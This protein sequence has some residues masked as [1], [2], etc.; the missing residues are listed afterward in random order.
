MSIH[1]SHVN[2]KRKVPRILL[3]KCTTSYK[4][5]ILKLNPYNMTKDIWVSRDCSFDNILKDI[6]E[7][8]QGKAL[9]IY[10]SQKEGFLK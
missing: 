8:L 7:K 3:Q 9:H 1:L 4:R 10:F 5:K 6:P 2:F